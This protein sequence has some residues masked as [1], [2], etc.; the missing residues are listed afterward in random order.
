MKDVEQAGRGRF[1][2]W[3]AGYDDWQPGHPG[4]VPPAAVALEPAEPESMPAE[5]AAAYVA[6]FNRAAWGGR[7]KIW[8]V[9]FPVKFCYRGDPQPGERIGDLRRRSPDVVIRTLGK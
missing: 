9:A 1:R 4:D 3:I 5:L 7:R 2:V 8:A 6:A